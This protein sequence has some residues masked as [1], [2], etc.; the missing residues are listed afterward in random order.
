TD[1]GESEGEPGLATGGDRM[2]EQGFRVTYATM[3][4][5]NE[6]LHSA[7]DEGI[8]QARKWLGQRHPFYVNGEPREGEGRFEERTPVDHDVE[9]SADLIRYYCHEMEQNE[10]FV[11]A[12]GRL[13]DQEKT[14]SAMKP[15]GVWGVIS[16]FNFPLALAAGP[17]G[18]ALVAGNTV[19]FK[20]SNAG[21]A[22]GVRLYECLH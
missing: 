12:M 22:M 14:F 18:G 1:T 5:D 7:Y 17:V 11:H 19:V 20:P 3:T 10:G 16:P 2:V 15:Y 21:A 8:E 9:E 13:S 4:A 6:E